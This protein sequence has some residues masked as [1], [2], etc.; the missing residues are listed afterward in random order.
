[1]DISD[2]PQELLLEQL[3]E[4]PVEDILSVCQT[5]LRLS[6]ICREERLWAR[7]L[8]RDFLD[9]NP[10]DLRALYMDFYRKS[11]KQLVS[12]L[13]VPWDFRLSVQ[14]NYDEWLRVFNIHEIEDWRAQ[15]SEVVPGLRAV[16]IFY[17]TSL[18]TR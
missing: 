13:R 11:K 6:E 14:D 17:A 5:N 9:V 8:Q 4:L 7:L 10:R 2:L 15:L 3:N 16:N 12:S 1:M 18:S